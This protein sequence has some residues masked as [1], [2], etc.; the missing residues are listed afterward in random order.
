[1]KMIL[2]PLLGCVAIFFGTPLLNESSLNP[3]GA[4][5]KMA[6]RAG[7]SIVDARG[8]PQDPFGGK[9]FTGMLQGAARGQV[10]VIRPA[11]QQH[12]DPMVGLTCTTR[13]WKALTGVGV[14]S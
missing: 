6:E 11:A 13:Y 1:M 2:V 7:L 5:N 12:T 14:D 4:Y 10:P 3:C 9:G 8:L